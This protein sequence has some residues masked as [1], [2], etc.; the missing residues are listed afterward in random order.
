MLSAAT[1]FDEASVDFWLRRGCRILKLASSDINDW[2]LI[3]KIA[4]TKKPVIAST[5]GSSLKDTDDLVMFFDNRNIP[6][7]VNHCVSLYPTEDH[8]LEMNQIDYLK[9]RYPNHVIGYSTHECHD[10]SS[11]MLIAYAKGARTA[12]SGTSTSRW[13]ALKCRPIARCRTRSTPGSRRLRWPRRCAGPRETQKRI[14]AAREIRYLDT[15]V[16]GVY[17]K[18]DLPEGHL[19][20]DNDVYLAV[21]LQKGQ[22]SC[23]ELVRGEMVLKTVRRDQPI[24]IDMIDSPYAYNAELKQLI[25]Q[26]GICSQAEPPSCQAPESAEGNGQHAAL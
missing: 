15:L 5:G 7:A 17:A 6:V 2:F 10:W 24:M 25:Y 9:A 21:P 18:H 22:I 1:P 3:E 16:R 20:T 13:T 11:S 23:R 12:S 4:K 14:S 8:E 19:L 26:R